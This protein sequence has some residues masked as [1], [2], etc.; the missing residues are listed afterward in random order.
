MAKLAL[1]ALR[2]LCHCQADPFH[3][4]YSFGSFLTR[5]R[6]LCVHGEEWVKKTD[7]KKSNTK[8]EERKLRW[9]EMYVS[10]GG[11]RLEGKQ[12]VVGVS[13]RED[14]EKRGMLLMRWRGR[15]MEG[16]IAIRNQMGQESV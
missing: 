5:F 12:E 4:K 16:S 1:K 11:W 15:L 9:L 3:C 7:H 2:T 13:E 6:V 8:L 14:F 10:A